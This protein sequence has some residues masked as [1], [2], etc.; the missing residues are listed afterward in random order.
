[1]ILEKVLNKGLK[2]IQLIHLFGIAYS[3]EPMSTCD[4]SN[5]ASYRQINT[6]VNG[7]KQLLKGEQVST[8][9]IRATHPVMDI[10]SRVL[11]YTLNHI[12]AVLTT[13]LFEK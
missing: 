10:N 7:S 8:L 9:L 3:N 4:H 6:L 1:M 5:T 11:C 13:M 2:F 12:V